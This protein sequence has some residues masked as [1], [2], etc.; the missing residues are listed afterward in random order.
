MHLHYYCVVPGCILIASHR[1]SL[2]GF[3]SGLPD[4]RAFDAAD[5]GWDY[6]TVRVIDSRTRLVSELCYSI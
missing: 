4:E 6:L 5:E 1:A 2:S 3:L